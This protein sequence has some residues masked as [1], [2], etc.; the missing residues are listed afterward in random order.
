[1][2]ADVDPIDRMVQE[3]ARVAPDLDVTPL[4]VVG[5]LL[6]CAAHLERMIGEA[7]Q[8]LGLTYGDFDV[9]NTLRRRGDPNGTYPKALA[10]SALVTSGA[11]TT[12]LDRLE[13]AGLIER[14][15]DAADRRAVLVRLTSVGQERAV[16]ALEAVLAVDR[17]F[18]EPLTPADHGTISDVL[19]RLLLRAEA[20]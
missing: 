11:M 18:L 3:W 17:R 2:D 20:G 13:R 14:Q 1:V 7:L 4:E 6:R 12:R 5:R 15:A 8:P 10:A 9:L 16:R 19:K